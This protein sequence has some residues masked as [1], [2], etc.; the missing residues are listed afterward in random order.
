MFLLKVSLEAWF[1]AQ[2]LIVI[3]IR[4]DVF[5]YQCVHNPSL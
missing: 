4:D 1:G 3:I 2:E 5:A